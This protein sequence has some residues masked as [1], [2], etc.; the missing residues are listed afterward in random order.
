MLHP[1][2]YDFVKLAS[3]DFKVGFAS[4]GVL[5]D[6]KKLSKLKASG[7]T[8]LDISVNMDTS[9][10]RIIDLIG[11]LKTANVLDID[12]RA[13]SVVRN[14]MEHDYISYLLRECKVRF[15]RQMIRDS[16]L[17]TEPCQAVGKVLV[18]LW[19]GTVVPCC[20]VV[21]KEIVY[22]KVGEKI[23]LSLDTLKNS[24]CKHCHEVDVEEV[25]RKL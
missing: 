5:L 7:L 10:Y 12:C 1:K 3:E 9:Y 23:D 22:G 11:L 19:D 24:Y 8:Y 14:K 6:I 18:I 13:R 15:Q 16:R 2:I 17:R 4:N 20:H 21:N 25:R